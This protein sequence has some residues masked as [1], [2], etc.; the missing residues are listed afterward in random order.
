MEEG[1]DCA[2]ATNVK[3]V[4]EYC[5]EFCYVI[6]ILIPIHFEIT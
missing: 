1:R 5:G 6:Y 2:V 3:M 4:C